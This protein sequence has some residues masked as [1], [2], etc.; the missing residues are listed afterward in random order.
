MTRRFTAE[1]A[2]K[3][4]SCYDHHPHGKAIWGIPDYV[5]A[6]RSEWRTDEGPFVEHGLGALIEAPSFTPHALRT[7][8]EPLLM[9][10]AWTG[11]VGGEYR[12]L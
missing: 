5:I 6:R 9:V 1:F 7:R 4:A 2:V 8:A 3:S 11:D 10:D 12:V